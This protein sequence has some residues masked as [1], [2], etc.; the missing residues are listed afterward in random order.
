MSLE[1][2]TQDEEE[3]QTLIDGLQKR[4]ISFENKAYES[5]KNALLTLGGSAV[6]GAQAY[7]AN[8]SGEIWP[9]EKYELALI[10]G[11]LGFVA[12]GHLAESYIH[13]VRAQR[14]RRMID[15]LQQEAEAE[16]LPVY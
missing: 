7:G 14:R 11:T 5:V 4:A 12:A 13:S 2:L 9:T 3:V 15:K 6:A 1:Y 8:K 10:A 16:N